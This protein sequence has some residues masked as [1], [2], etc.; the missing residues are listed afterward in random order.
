MHQPPRR[1]PKNHGKGWKNMTN[2]YKFWALALTFCLLAAPAMADDKEGA[3]V[4]ITAGQSV[5]RNGCQSA[6]VTSFAA[7]GSKATCSE[8]STVYRVGFGYQYTPMWGLEANYGTMGYAGQDGYAF[9]PGYATASSYSWQMKAAGLA[10]QAVATMHM[11]DSLAVFGKFGLARVEFTEYMYSWNI[12]IPAP[13][14]NN[15][16]S[17][18]VNTT[19]TTPALGAGI[20]YDVTP[21]ASVLAL[22][23]SYGSHD[24]YNLYGNGTKVRLLSAS[25]GLMYKY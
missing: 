12:N 24:I 10:I 17:P 6:W 5:M 9:L 15:Y 20:K 2:R 1:H 22:V 21:H 7:L 23:E 3:Y 18:V 8:K 13:F 14:T 11:S 16:W 19:R 4:F 25:A